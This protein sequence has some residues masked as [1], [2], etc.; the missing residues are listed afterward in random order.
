MDFMKGI[1]IILVK[2]DEIYDIM[3]SLQALVIGTEMRLKLD[4]RSFY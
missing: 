1:V 3:K 4:N 2:Q